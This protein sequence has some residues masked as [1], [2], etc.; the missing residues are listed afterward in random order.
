MNP[1]I[2]NSEEY[3]GNVTIFLSNG[4]EISFETSKLN[5]FIEE[6]KLNVS[7]ENQG[8]GLVCDPNGTDDYV[9][10]TIPVEKWIDDNFDAAVASYYLNVICK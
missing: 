6:N 5:D 4:H 3:R 1:T 8:T 10:I 7:T 2:K 9:E